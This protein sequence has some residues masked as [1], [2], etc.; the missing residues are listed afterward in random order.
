MRNIICVSSKILHLCKCVINNM[1]QVL[2]HILLPSFCVA[3][4]ANIGSAE[5]FLIKNNPDTP[6][7]WDDK[8][9]STG[10][11]S[12]AV[13]SEYIPGYYDES[14]GI[15]TRDAVLMFP[16]GSCAQPRRVCKFN[17]GLK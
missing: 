10:S 7:N 11:Y 4:L 16:G 9:W 2:R 13:A 12:D 5:T 1:I 14:S 8:I 6:L 15:D 17:T 3:I